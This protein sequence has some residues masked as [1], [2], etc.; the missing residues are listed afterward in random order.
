MHIHVVV[1]HLPHSLPTL[2][3]FTATHV[4]APHS[5]LA[6][7][8]SSHDT[9]EQST[10][11]S[12]WLWRPTPP[13]ISGG[14]GPV[15]QRDFGTGLESI[16]RINVQPDGAAAG[17]GTFEVSLTDRP[18]SEE[19]VPCVTGVN[20]AFLWWG[21]DPGLGLGWLLVTLS[22]LAGCLSSV[23][24]SASDCRLRSLRC[25]G[26]SSNECGAHHVSSRPSCWVGH[27]EWLLLGGVVEYDAIGQQRQVTSC[28]ATRGHS[29]SG[30][31]SS[32][33]CPI[34]GRSRHMGVSQWRDAAGVIG[35]VFRRRPSR[36]LRC[37]SCS[38]FT[39][40]AQMRS[41]RALA[42]QGL[43]MAATWRDA[44]RAETP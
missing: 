10:N 12:H 4:C 23:S 34:A 35:R 36:R 2:L 42:G 17:E 41:G 27:S 3:V 8:V 19:G 22:L 15:R 37:T 39:K 44:Q 16:E 28:D 11:L 14:P 33:A 20:R 43:R 5:T 18:V 25:N 24:D 38:S 1:L 26:S 9:P 40:V 29:S 6:D 13:R 7:H 30:S 32:Q 31:C 21:E